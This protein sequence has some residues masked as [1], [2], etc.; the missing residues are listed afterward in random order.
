M[1]LYVL[2]KL[3]VIANL[4]ANDSQ[5][6]SIICIT[7]SFWR[8]QDELWIE[9]LQRSISG[10]IVIKNSQKFFFKKKSHNDSVSQNPYIQTLV[11]HCSP[12]ETN[13]ISI[14]NNKHNICQQDWTK[15]VFWIWGKI[16]RIYV[17]LHKHNKM[18]L[19]C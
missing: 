13:S 10:M 14:V 19:T 18:Q 8:C 1:A 17:C 15:M 9:N 16:K 2:I 6:C 11:F 3:I 4:M 5:N 12:D 7:G